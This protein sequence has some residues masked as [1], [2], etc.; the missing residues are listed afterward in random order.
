M[1]AAVAVL[2][3]GV[4]AIVHILVALIS[5][6]MVH[7]TIFFYERSKLKEE[8]SGENTSIPRQQQKSCY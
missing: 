4:E 6:L 7:Y 8:F 3:M 1:L 2:A 5:V